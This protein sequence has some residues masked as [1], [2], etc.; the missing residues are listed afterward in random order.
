VKFSLGQLN[1]YSSPEPEYSS[2]AVIRVGQQMRRWYAEGLGEVLAREERTALQ[3][4]LPM[5]F[6]YHLVQLGYLYDT[7]YLAESC[8]RHKVVADPDLTLPASQRMLLA[9]AAQIPLASDSVDVVILP[10]T[11]EMHPQPH[12]VLREVERILIPEGHVV[13]LVFNPWSLWGMRRALTF[14]E[15]KQAPWCCRFI[16]PIRTKDWLE[17]LG[18]QVREVRT[19]FHRPPI[20]HPE[21]Q[22]WMAP[23]DGWGERLWPAF[24]GV[25]LYV[26]RKRV[27]PIT[28]IKPRWQRKRRLLAADLVETRNGYQ[29]K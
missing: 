24:G 5:L 20:G 18:F 23:L 11:L 2:E 6:G 10:H 4:V 15:N 13:L 7:D 25:T 12:Q 26:V 19:F 3:Q 21:V 28:P 17:V 29:R 8:V 9:D 27:I 22:R 1:G 14:G 16:N